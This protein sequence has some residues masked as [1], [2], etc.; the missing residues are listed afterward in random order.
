[1]K[2]HAAIEGKEVADTL[3]K[4][5]A[6]EVEDRNCV[7]DKIPV[8]TIA[9]RVKKEGLRKWQE[10]WE[11]AVKGAIWGAFFPKVEKRLRLR[12][13]ITPE[14]T[15][16]VSGHGKT[17]AYLNRFKIIDEPM[18]PCNEEE[19]T[20][21]HLIYLC[22]ILEPSRSNMIKHITTRGEIWTPTNNEL[23]DKYITDLQKLLNL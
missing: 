3:A 20:V 6:Q 2:A 5:A 11:R 9:S 10:L 12:I 15:A 7:Y 21:V 4:E 22:S 13:Q 17:K 8:S 19:Q 14:Y 16:I 18:C 1:M 23:I